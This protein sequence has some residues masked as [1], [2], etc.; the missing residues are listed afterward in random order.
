MVHDLPDEGEV[1]ELVNNTELSEQEKRDE[2]ARM[3]IENIDEVLN[4]F[5]LRPY[6]HSIAHMLGHPLG[7]FETISETRWSN[8]LAYIEEVAASIRC[9][10]ICVFR[11]YYYPTSEH[12]CPHTPLFIYWRVN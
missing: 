1:R 3:G 2:L 7:E 4:Y 11:P 10:R 6:E 9:A 12:M 8:Y 5:R